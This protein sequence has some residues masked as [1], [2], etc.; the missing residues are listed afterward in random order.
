[1]SSCLSGNLPGGANKESKLDPSD[2]VIVRHLRI[3]IKSFYRKRNLAFGYM[4][5]IFDDKGF[6]KPGIS[7]QITCI[8]ILKVHI[9]KYYTDI[10]IQQIQ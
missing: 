4:I 6:N 9:Y 5:V 8:Q 10:Y 2:L 1:M 3:K 7:T